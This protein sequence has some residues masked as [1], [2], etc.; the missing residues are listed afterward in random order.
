MK[1]TSCY[2]RQI[3]ENIH[4]YTHTT[5]LSSYIH[6]NNM[7]VNK[8]CSAEQVDTHGCSFPS[9]AQPTVAL[10]SLYW[11]SYV[12]Q[13]G[14]FSECWPNNGPHRVAPFVSAPTL[15]STRVQEITNVRAPLRCTYLNTLPVSSTSPNRHPQ[16]K[17]YLTHFFFYHKTPSQLCF[18]AA[19]IQ[20]SSFLLRQLAPFALVPTANHYLDI[21][22]VMCCLYYIMSDN[23]NFF[24]TKMLKSPT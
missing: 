8:Q 13:V 18:A 3:D 19:F 15:G 4:T 22:G 11:Y 16:T 10:S 5:S 1:I 21:V 23:S 9:H 7:W 2:L 20:K 6:L 17:P 12:I 14:I 24:S